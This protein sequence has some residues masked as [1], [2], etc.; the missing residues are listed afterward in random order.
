LASIKNLITTKKGGNNMSYELT[1]E[2]INNILNAEGEVRGV[3]FKTDR[4]FI[5]DTAGEEGLKKVEEELE[6]MN[7][8][9]NYE[10]EADN[11]SFYPIGMRVLSLIAISRAFNLEREGIMKMGSNAPKFSLMIKFFMRYFLSVEKIMEKAGE[12][13]EKH[14]TVGKLEHVEMNVEEKFMRAK[15]YDINLHPIMCDYLTGY[16]SS[17]IKMGVGEEVKT[18][19]VTCIHKG[20]DYHEFTTKW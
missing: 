3:V 5:T 9:F 7:C 8:P 19:E 6:K 10:E 16:F 14:Y 11:M 12:I 15:L 17:I 13:W 4:R 2:Q 1:D 18:E 20:G